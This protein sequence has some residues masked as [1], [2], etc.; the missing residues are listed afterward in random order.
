MIVV[1]EKQCASC[2]ETKP[3]KE[4]KRKL[5][6]AQSRA[7]LRNPKI[8]T[9][10]IADSKRCKSCQQELKRHTPLSIKDIRNKVST[11][12]MHS[13]IGE[14]QI[15]QM[16]DALPKKRAKV[17][18]EYWQEKK[19][20]PIKELQDSLQQQVATYARRYHSYKA[21]KTAQ[22]AMLEQHS[23]NYEQAKQIRDDLLDRARAGEKIAVDVKINELI[24]RRK[25]GQ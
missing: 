25:V 18:K 3:S 23:Y 24:K 19:A 15:K 22:H 16:R 12:D 17:M 11:G 13:V 6:I 20:K 5:T 21:T 2:G 8:T 9:P 1:R 14:A 4:F 7:M 10:Y